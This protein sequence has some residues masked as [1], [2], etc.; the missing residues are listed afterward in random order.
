MAIGMERDAIAQV[1]RT[2][3]YKDWQK[4]GDEALIR[5]GIDLMV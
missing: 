4:L 2:C 1:S 3:L 5:P